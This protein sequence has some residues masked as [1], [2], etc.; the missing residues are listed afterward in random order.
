[1]IIKE[2]QGYSLIAMVMLLQITGLLL[3]ISLDQRLSEQ[4]YL[5][6]DER[7]FLRAKNQALSSLSWGL[8]QSWPKPSNNWRCLQ[9]NHHQLYACLKLSSQDN[10]ALLVG[11]SQTSSDEDPIR[12]YHWVHLPIAWQNKESIFL[13][14]HARGWL[15]FCPESSESI[16]I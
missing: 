4:L 16:C 10:K 13:I 3:L 6:S 14:K 8:V 1:M 11:Y 12:F 15:D 7:V 5:Y 9:N 2:Q